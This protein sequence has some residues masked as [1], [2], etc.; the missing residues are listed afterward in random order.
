MRRFNLIR[1]KINSIDRKVVNLLEKR[2]SLA[3]KLGRIKKESG[4]DIE[5]TAYEREH[6]DE[7][8]QKSSLRPIFLRGIFN[9]IFSESKKT[10]R[11]S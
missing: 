2:M 6:L 5:D 9:E 1:K 3:R 10:Q 4:E 7:L 8:A 11:W